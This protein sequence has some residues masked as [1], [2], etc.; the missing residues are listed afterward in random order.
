[1]EVAPAGLKGNGLFAKQRISKGQF[2]IE[3]IGEVIN[4]EHVQKRLT[5]KCFYALLLKKG[6]FIDSSVAGNEARFINHSCDPNA[7]ADYVY[8]GNEKRV[9]IFALKTI[10]KG[11]EITFDYLYE[12]WGETPAKCYCGSANC[13]GFMDKKIH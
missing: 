3:Y 7:I 9:G 12:D 10:E 11:E 1:M 6:M 5:K 4:Q 2:I 13:T 8:V